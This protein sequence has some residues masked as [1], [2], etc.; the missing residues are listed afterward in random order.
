[1]RAVR[2]FH[3]VNLKG[4]HKK[5]NSPITKIKPSNHFSPFYFSGPG[6]LTYWR[7]VL[8]NLPQ[9]RAAFV[10]H[11]QAPTHMDTAADGKS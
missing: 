4:E 3:C 2:T 5:M 9:G 11:P 1:M 7:K 8:T 10:A 6:I